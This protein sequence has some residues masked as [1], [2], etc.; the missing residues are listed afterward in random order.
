MAKLNVESVPPVG[1]MPLP[2]AEV[3]D[4]EEVE[5]VDDVLVEVVLLPVPEQ[6]APQDDIASLTHC[7]SHLL[8]QQYESPAQTVVAQGSHPLVSAVPVAHGECEQVPM[9]ELV[10]VVL[11]AVVEVV[12]VADVVVVEVDVLVP[13]ILL[14][15][16]FV[17][18]MQTL[19]A[20]PSV[21]LAG[22]HAVPVG[23]AWPLL[24]SEAQ[25]VSPANCAQ[26]EPAP[27]AVVVTQTAHWPPLEPVEEPVVAPAPAPEDSPPKPLVSPVLAQEAARPAPRPALKRRAMRVAETENFMAAHA[28]VTNLKL[29]VQG[30]PRLGPFCQDSARHGRRRARWVQIRHVAGKAPGPNCR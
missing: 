14:P 2:L 11:V 9:P 5:E 8:L 28:R 7:W 4:V 13:L 20:L 22:V 10:D 15:Q 30:K 16:G 23:H 29:Q 12:V 3:D 1:P 25:Y 26:S 19:T 17:T 24:Q 21:V 18:G 6:E 27:Q